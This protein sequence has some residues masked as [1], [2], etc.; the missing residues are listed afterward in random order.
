MSCPGFVYTP[1]G[2]EGIGVIQPQS[3]LDYPLVKPSED[4]RY[5][6]ADF[7][8]AYDDRGEYAVDRPKVVLPLRIK[9]LY[10]VGCTPND[11]PAGAPTPRAGHADIVVVDANDVEVFNTTTG[12][13]AE[14]VHEWNTDYKVYEWKTTTGTC[15]LVAHTNWKTGEPDAVQYSRYITPVSGQ[16]DARAVYKMP[17]R[18]LSLSTRARSGTAVHGPY[19]GKITFRNSYNTTLVPAATTNNNYLTKTNITIA[20]VAGSGLGY[21]PEC[22]SGFD[23]DNNPLPQPIRRIN[24]V[25]A[26]TGGD[27][28]LAGND[29]LYVRRPTNQVGTTI[30][31]STTAQQK[32]GAD[33]TP[34]CECDDYVTTALYM[35]S[36]QSRY[37]LIGERVTGIKLIHEQN[38]ERWQDKRACS[39]TTPLK[40]ILVPQGCPYMDIVAMVCNPCD[41]CLSGSQLTLVLEPV[42]TLTSISAELICGYTA[43]FAPG[44]NGR[45]TP[46]DLAQNS[47]NITATFK[48]P[49]VNP[50]A[51]A[52]LKFR[53]KFSPRR[54]YAVKGTLTGVLDEPA[55]A[56]ILGGCTEETPEEERL[57]A[58][59]IATQALYCDEAGETDMPC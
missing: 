56:P 5:L 13:Q 35:N 43:L 11:L 18:L 37:S 39:L 59:A 20:A 53:L 23:E 26:A 1:H 6:L 42:E 47:T 49:A 58:S 50:G 17:R 3:G 34:C 55:G 36:V 16:L 14:S 54:S 52:Y 31:P 45:P 28:V 10:N 22:G 32:I 30:V 8:L 15:R 46:I 12:V 9:H 21:Y 44:I 51:S 33:C 19:T 2:R 41:T 57:V 7:Y 40:L 29:C 38:I 27:F 4:I 24:G 25:G 48:M